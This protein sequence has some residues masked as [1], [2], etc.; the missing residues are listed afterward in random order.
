MMTPEA[1]AEMLGEQAAPGVWN[2][3]GSATPEDHLVST[4]NKGPELS[5][6]SSKFRI[7]V[8]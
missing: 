5:P 3:Y 1:G 6:S 4:A 8:A 7:P 2:A